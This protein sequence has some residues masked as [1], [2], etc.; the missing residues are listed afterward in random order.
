MPSTADRHVRVDLPPDH[1]VPP[2]R[3]AWLDHHGVRDH[4]REIAFARTRDHWHLAIH[5]FGYART[6][7]HPVV[8]IHGLA[9]NR[10]TFDL[11][12]ERSFARH[13]AARGFD[14]F[15][16]ELRGH[17]RSEQ[18]GTRP[19]LPD[20]LERRG[21]LG[22]APSKHWDWDFDR[23]VD[24][25]LDA[26]FDVILAW[27]GASALHAIGHSMGGIALAVRA[28]REDPRL[29]SVAT[30]ASALDY[31]GTESV[32]HAAR[33]LLWMTRIIQVVPLGPL[34]AAL[35]PVALAFPNPIDAVNVWH[36]NVEVA[37]YRRLVALGFHP[38]PGDVLA[39]LA[40]AFVRPGMKDDGVPVAPTLP[41]RTPILA[42]A[43]SK[44]VQ[45]TPEAAARHAGGRSLAFGRAHGH[46]ED[47]GH[48]DLLMGTHA[49][50]AVWP[51]LEAWL[52]DHD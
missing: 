44:D 25:D 12:D 35:S 10:F 50:S 34:A 17:G 30:V 14:V 28:G 42:V 18:P 16:L 19:P 52:E 5:R 8:L 24:F 27:S 49:P 13:L 20:E 45:C 41:K 31:S 23:Y 29:R 32:F 46:P 47:F 37:R 9:A 40:A 26:A 22:N 15:V 43:G 21:R 1:F 7:R 48:F 33:R 6:R 2:R 3:R 38:I 4:A 36:R 39:D 11:D 51:E